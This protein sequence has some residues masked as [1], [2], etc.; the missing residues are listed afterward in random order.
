MFNPPGQRRD[1]VGSKP[2]PGAT[3]LTMKDL[4]KRFRTVLN[5]QKLSHLKDDIV[6]GYTNGRTIHASDLSEVELKSLIESLQKPVKKAAPDK[7]DKI[8][9]GIFHIAYQMDIIS[10]EMTSAEKTARIEEYIQKHEK[11]GNKKHLN[12][13][14]VPEL[15]KLFHQFKINL[16]WYLNKKF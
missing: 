14:S 3:R 10:A 7:G 6:S 5:E 8:R 1:A 13:Y 4:I 16:V 15:Q 12:E 2:A 9:K 11:M